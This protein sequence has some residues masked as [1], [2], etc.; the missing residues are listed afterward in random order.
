VGKTGSLS[1]YESDGPQKM[2]DG[3]LLLLL[4]KQKFFTASTDKSSSNSQHT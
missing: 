3:E 1:S 2:Q 4:T